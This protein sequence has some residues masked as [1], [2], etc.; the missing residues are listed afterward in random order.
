RMPPEF[1]GAASWESYEPEG[2]A[3]VI[4]WGNHHPN[5]CLLD[6]GSSIGFYSLVGLF[7][8]PET[9]V[10]AFDSDLRSLKAAQRLCRDVTGDR[11]SVVHGFLSDRHLSGQNLAEAE[12][13]TAAGLKA[14]RATGDPGS[15]QYICLIDNIDATIPTHSLDGLLAASSVVRAPILLKC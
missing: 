7:S 4:A 11:L 5:G 10:I 12:S 2:V 14:S 8:S 15:N 6:I 3:A 9:R 1:T 13:Q